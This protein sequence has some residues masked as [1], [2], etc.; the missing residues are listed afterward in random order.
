MNSI[1][2]TQFRIWATQRLREY[3]A[4][5]YVIDKRRFD[6]NAAELQQ[7]IA[8]IQKTAKS[9][10]LST[11]ADRGLIDIKSLPIEHSKAKPHTC[12]ISS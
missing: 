6:Q 4:Q 10:K 12:C 2:G 5:G 11:D 9:P 8:L 7:A 3:L 1:K